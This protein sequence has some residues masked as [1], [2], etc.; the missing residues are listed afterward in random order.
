MRPARIVVTAGPTR[1][2]VDPVR[3][4]SN[5]STGTFGYAIAAEAC[6][7]GHKVF[8]VSGPTFIQA[9][10]GV[11]RIMVES[12][13]EMR[14]AVMRFARKADCIIMA[15]AISDWRPER[16][17]AHKMKRLKA[18]TA[19]RLIAN[20]DI[21]QELGRKNLGAT[22]VGFALETRDTLRNARN[23]LKKKNLDFIIANRTGGTAGAFGDKKTDIALIDRQGNT[24]RFYRKT[25]REL[26]KIIID[27]VL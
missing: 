3:F 23:K 13:L 7:R 12:A 25:K 2:R 5:Y 9:P 11:R 15:A 21:L 1:E 16:V 26:A 24:T 17:S 19:L 20:P 22:L 14:R 6:R 10:S 4:L 18:S 8:L 27:K